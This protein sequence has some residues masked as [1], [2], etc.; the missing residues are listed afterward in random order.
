MVKQRRNNSYVYI[1]MPIKGMVSIAIVTGILYDYTDMQCMHG[2]YSMNS[3]TLSTTHSQCSLVDQALCNSLEIRHLGTRTSTQHYNN[4]CFNLSLKGFI[5]QSIL[6]IYVSRSILGLNFFDHWG[7]NEPFQ[8]HVYK[9]TKV[10]TTSHEH[11]K[12]VGSN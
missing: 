8:R 12:E 9:L 6:S 1:H 7:C 3:Y 4:G 5:F 10:L 11:I 2:M